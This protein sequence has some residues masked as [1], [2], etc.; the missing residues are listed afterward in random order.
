M[1][2]QLADKPA[3]KRREYFNRDFKLNLVALCKTGQR[4][5]SS[6]AREHD[7][8]VN[9]LFRWIREFSEMPCGDTEPRMLPVCVTDDDSLNANPIQPQKLDSPSRNRTGTDIGSIVLTTRN[10]CSLQII[11]RP[12]D[13]LLRRVLQMA[14]A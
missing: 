9:L 4:S 2:L 10:G 12:D 13:D 8:H 5:V 1:D 11:G 7:I 6:I 3:R 14:F